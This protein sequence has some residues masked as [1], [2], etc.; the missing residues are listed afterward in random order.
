MILYQTPT[1]PLPH[2]ALYKYH[3]LIFVED[4]LSTILTP[5]LFI[6]ILPPHAPHLCS[7]LRDNTTHIPGLGDLCTHAQFDFE[8]HGNVKYGSPVPGPKR[9]RSRQG[10]VEKSALAFLAMYPTWRAPWGVRQLAKNVVGEGDVEVSV[11]GGSMGGVTENSGLIGVG[12]VGS[13]GETGGGGGDD[14]DVGGVRVKEIVARFER[15]GESIEGGHSTGSGGN[16]AGNANVNVSVNG[17]S[18]GISGGC[19][20]GGKCG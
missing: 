19:V 13:H 15:G 1:P 5:L 3:I 16:S 10:K 8:R 9:L 7:F 18:S 2:Q 20:E 4:I 17:R 11:S 14:D 12:V 6:F